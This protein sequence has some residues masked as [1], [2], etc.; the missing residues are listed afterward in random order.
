MGSRLG[1]SVHISC[2]MLLIVSTFCL[3][4]RSSAVLPYCASTGARDTAPSALCKQLQSSEVQY[5]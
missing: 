5:L 4:V 3:K 2:G 1:P